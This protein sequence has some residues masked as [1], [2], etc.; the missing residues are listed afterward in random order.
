VRDL[1]VAYGPVIAVDGVDLAAYRGEVLAL[2]GPNGAGK[3]TVLDAIAGTAPMTAGSVLLDGTELAGERA[4]RRR[5]AGIGRVFQTPRLAGPTPMDDVVLAAA[6]SRGLFSGIVQRPGPEADAMAEA[7]LGEVELEPSLWRVPVG[8]L[9]LPDQRRVE[10]ARALVAEPC[11][12]LLDEPASGLPAS[13]RDGF[14]DLVRTLAGPERGVILVEH[15]MA[16]VA[17][18]AHNVIALD[19]GRAVHEGSYASVAAD[20]TVRVSYLGD[21][22]GEPARP[23]RRARKGLGED[24]GPAVLSLRA[25][26][27]QHGA[28]TVLHGLDIDV[29]AGE[30]VA[31][32]GPNGAGKTTLARCLMGLHSNM[33]GSVTVD[34]VALAPGES[35]SRGA[36]GLAGV[37]DTRD[38]VPSLTVDR[39]LGLVL[40]AAGRA[41]AGDLFER[42]SELGGRRCSQLSGG[43]AQLVAL[44]RALGTQPKALVI[45]ELSQGLAP[46]AL[47]A[48]LPAVRASAD[49]GCA[50]LL[51]EQFA[52]A[53]SLVADRIVLLDTGRVVYDGPVAG[54][55]ISDGY[56]RPEDADPPAATAI[57]TDLT[58]GMLP[59]QRRALGKLAVRTGIPAG[60][61]VRDAVDR[62]LATEDD[63]SAT[64]DGAAMTNGR[65]RRQPLRAPR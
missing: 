5:L 55:P 30:V 56:L 39:Y 36:I 65:R 46:V 63:G 11:L 52:A 60:Q 35:R 1:T 57:L 15:D 10:L 61:L 26:E 3:S 59:S 50:V 27:A 25:V 64:S 31:V 21:D 19:R 14:A 38:L 43:E 48:L 20:P 4:A 45:D 29:A 41:R 62:L 28:A 58:L 13:E 42:L 7:A 32:L 24:A 8:R 53:A 18:A 23:R 2:I 12:L 33:S 54:A 16:L 6:K 44:A 9:G 49:S 22:A 40:D 47:K 17:R 51:I 34:G 37:G